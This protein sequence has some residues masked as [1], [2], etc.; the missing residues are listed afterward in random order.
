M[1]RR[2]VVEPLGLGGRDDQRGGVDVGTRTGERTGEC[3]LGVLDLFCDCDVFD[4]ESRGVV[5]VSEW[6]VGERYYG[7]GVD[8][9]LRGDEEEEG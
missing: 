5:F 8:A 1:R 3:L 7:G 9:S 6:K 2:R 4:D